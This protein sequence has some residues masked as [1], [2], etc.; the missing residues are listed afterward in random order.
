MGTIYFPNL[1]WEL[2]V[3]KSF[4]IGS[5]TIAFYGII[6]ALGIIAGA[7]LAYSEASRTGQDVDKYIDYTIFGLIGA[8]LGARIYYVAFEWD[9]YKDNLAEIFNL[10]G[11]GLAIYGAIIGAI[12]VL[13]IFS[14]IKKVRFFQFLD[15]MMFGIILGQIIGRWGNFFNREAFGGYTDSLFAMRIPLEDAS[16]SADML[17]TY[18]SMLI[19]VDGA[20]YIQVHP[21]FLYESVLNLV[22]LALMLIFRD[23]KKFYGENVCRYMVGYGLVRF[24]IEG[25]RTDQLKVG[26]V[27]VSQILSAVL[28]AIGLGII[29]FMRVRL[30][31]KPALI[32]PIPTKEEL[33]EIKRKRKEEDAAKKAAKSTAEIYTVS[34]K[35]KDA[36]KDAAEESAKDAAEEKT[37]ANVMKKKADAAAEAAEEVAEE[38]AEKANEAAEKVEE[39]AEKAESTEE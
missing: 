29:V 13:I 33:A 22:V 15:T 1:G 30:I 19:E 20:Q 16:V 23:K 2:T 17:T 6:I 35:S 34:S 36:A 4:S 37:I 21:T 12:I 38:A 31:G 3:G 8:I 18:S 24:F 25:L 39:A 28:F 5:F 7:A 11:G 26:N 9:Y 10:R 32:D 14:K 27:A